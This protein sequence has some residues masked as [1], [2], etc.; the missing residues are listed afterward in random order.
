M[1]WTPS[2]QGCSNVH[3][4]YFWQMFTDWT[5]GDSSYTRRR[6]TPVGVQGLH[7]VLNLHLCS[8]TWHKSPAFWCRCK[9]LFHVVCSRLLP[10]WIQRRKMRLTCSWMVLLY[11]R[12]SSQTGLGQTFISPACVQMSLSMC[13]KVL[14]RVYG[15]GWFTFP[16]LGPHSWTR[17]TR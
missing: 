17:N 12:V 8:H 5:R 14:R 16:F 11:G 3:A 2:L 4:H 15:I 7:Q 13:P 9:W 10:A 6:Q 1:E